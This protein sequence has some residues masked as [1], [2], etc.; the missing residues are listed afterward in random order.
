MKVYT[1]YDVIAQEY[2]FP[3]FAKTDEAACRSVRKIV[4]E[5]GLTES[6]FKLYSISVYDQIE[7]VMAETFVKE[8]IPWTHFI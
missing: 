7:G 6:D 4:K 1:L 5:Q 8:E 2:G 3:F